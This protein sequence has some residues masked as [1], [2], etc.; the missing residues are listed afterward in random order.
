MNR[1]KV[2]LK[3]DFRTKLFMAVTL[4]YTLILG[5]IQQNHPIVAAA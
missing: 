4:S 5:N 2:F 3:I 1:E